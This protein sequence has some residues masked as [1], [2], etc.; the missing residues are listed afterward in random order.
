MERSKIYGIVGSALFCLLTFLILWFVVM[1]SV[2][3]PVED[4]GIMVSFGDN[5]DGLGFGD[6]IAGVQESTAPSIPPQNTEQQ[7][8]LT[9][10]TEQSVV[11]PKQ[12]VKPKTTTRTVTEQDIQRQ[13]QQR[14]EA[15]V[16]AEAQ[17]KAEAAAR[18]ENLVGS[19]FGSGGGSGSGTTSGDTRQGN[20]AG[21]GTSGGH[22]WSLSGRSL[23]SKLSDP[24]YTKN[25]EGKITVNIRVDANGIVTNP[26]IGTPTD[27]SDAQIRSAAL[28]AA[29]K[30][31][32]SA[33]SGVSFG[34]ITYYFKL[35]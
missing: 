9:Q 21:S 31:R 4:E 18:S 22:G 3:K 19:A 30:A 35:N 28:S 13:E 8:I 34:T 23:V 14:R 33:G 15:A 20:P 12:Q 6:M 7:E 17:R 26:T 27:I 5:M 10:E 1:P 25:V 11:V 32:F 29:K 2:A 24:V 16:A